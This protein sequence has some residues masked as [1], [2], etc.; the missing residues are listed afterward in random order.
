V[1]AHD[2]WGPDADPAGVHSKGTLVSMSHPVERF[3]PAED[4]IGPTAV[5][6]L[7]QRATYA[8]HETEMYRRI[9]E[10]GACTFVGFRSSS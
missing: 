2:P 3:A 4:S 9:A 5:V 8:E 6:A 7:F 1:I 10:R